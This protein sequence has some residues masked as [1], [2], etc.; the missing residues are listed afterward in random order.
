MNLSAEQRIIRE[1]IQLLKHYPFFG[2]LSLGLKL[3]EGSSISTMGTDGI[4]LIY[5]AVYVAQLEDKILRAIIAH[6]VL[7]CALGHLW[8]KENRSHDR[9]NI[10]A[11]HAV[12]LTLKK[13]GFTLP[14]NICC[15]EKYE[16]M[17]AEMIYAR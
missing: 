13:E 17:S 3:M 12:N 5:N 6:E 7:H 15:D 4:H 11:D 9:W 8:R 16:N 1:R 14:K 10:A 2:H